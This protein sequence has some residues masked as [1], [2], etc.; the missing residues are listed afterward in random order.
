M[1]DCI[2]QW[3]EVA[4]TSNS[5]Q[6]RR[7]IGVLEAAAWDP[8]ER[9]ELAFVTGA[10]KGRVRMLAWDEALGR[11]IVSQDF[12]CSNV[13]ESPVVELHFAAG[14]LT[15]EAWSAT[16]TRSGFYRTAVG[17]RWQAADATSAVELEVDPTVHEKT[18][19]RAE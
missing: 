18:C 10:A 7:F 14:G 12:D 4:R 9:A 1:G 17:E 5:V 3:C 13:D 8:L 15:L 2:G 11:F 19:C 6:S 16:G